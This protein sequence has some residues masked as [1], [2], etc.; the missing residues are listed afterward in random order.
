MSKNPGLAAPCSSKD[1]EGAVDINDGL[2]LRFI[3]LA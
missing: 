3:Q 2:S 1:E